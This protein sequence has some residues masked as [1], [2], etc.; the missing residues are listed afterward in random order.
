MVRDIAP[1]KMDTEAR[2]LLEACSSCMLALAASADMSFEDISDLVMKCLPSSYGEAEKR[3][4]TRMF[5][6]AYVEQYNMLTGKVKQ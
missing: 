4:Y 2:V 3:Y 1:L 5:E 6:Y